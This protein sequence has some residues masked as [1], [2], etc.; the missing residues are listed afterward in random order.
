MNRRGRPAG[1]NSTET[2]KRIIDAARA[3]FADRGYAAAAITTIAEQARLTPGSIYHYYS[4][5]PALYEA[6]FDA[7]ASVLWSDFGI[8]VAGFDSAVD[9]IDAIIDDARQLKHTRSHYND[10]LAN[11]PIEARLHP[12]FAH[13]LTHRSKYQD[14]VFGAIAELGLSTGEFAGFDLKHATELVRSPIM[15]W[16]FERHFRGPE[17]PGSGEAIL[18]LFEILA[19]R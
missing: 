17:M 10:F 1:S 7:T 19:D 2:R 5:K 4:G 16:F 8:R 18:R 12:E 15:G 6:V 14:E 9:A 3:E 13:L 11:V